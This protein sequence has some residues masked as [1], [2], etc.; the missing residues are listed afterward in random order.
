MLKYFLILAGLFSFELARA[1][2]N[3]KSKGPLYEDKFISVEIEY[4]T[5]SDPCTPGVTLSQYRYKIT[6][7]RA[8]G[9][10]YINWR[11]DYFNCD[12]QLKT[13][14]NSLLITQSTHIGY[15]TPPDNQFPALKLVNTVNTVVKSGSLPE[16]TAYEPISSVSLEPKVITGTLAIDKGGQATLAFLGGYL[17]GHTAWKWHEGDCE[18]PVIGT[19]DKITV[20]PLKTTTYVLRGEGQYPTPCIKT[21]VT[22][23][24]LSQAPASINGKTLLCEG[25]KNMPLTVVGGRLADDARWVWYK[26]HCGGTAMGTGETLW[27]SPEETTTYYVRAEGPGGETECRHI[28]VVPATKSRKPV[29]IDGPVKVA[30]GEAFTLTVQGG[31]LSPEAKWVWY[32]GDIDHKRE[33]CRGISCTIPAGIADDTYYVRAEGACYN[34]E[35]LTRLVRVSDSKKQE[36]FTPE[37]NALGKKPLSVFINGGAVTND[38]S[39]L[40]GIK[41]YVATIGGGRNIGWFVRG[42]ISGDQSKADYE[43]TG[44]QI[45]NYNRAGYYQYNNQVV[46][47]RTGYTGGIYLGG[48]YWAVYLGGG[49]GTRELLY[50]I[51]QNTYDQTFSSQSSWVKNTTYSYSGAETEGGLILKTGFLNLMGGVSNIAGK[52]TDY[53]LGIGLSF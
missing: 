35:F 16:V 5:G 52:Y 43:S 34:T 19:G 41:N 47:K 10:F 38:P 40:K 48:R 4:A 23:L 11:F 13:H 14:A 50:G 6:R 8:P 9:R 39:Q 25:E 46:S 22:V 3:W 44:M 51:N 28:E 31:E 49:Y 18:G 36:G 29:S 2:P 7:L 12:H 26:D 45:L 30:F 20:K 42:K 27:V 17:A 1:Q 24:N 37:N 33:L 32:A 53:N 21:V 15:F